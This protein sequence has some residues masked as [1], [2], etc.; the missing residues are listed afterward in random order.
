MMK[1]RV[2]S[3]I[4]LPYESVME[5]SEMARMVVVKNPEGFA[6]PLEVTGFESSDGY[7]YSPEKVARNVI[8][9]LVS[10]GAIEDVDWKYRYDAITLAEDTRNSTAELELYV[11]IDVTEELRR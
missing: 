7:W 6:D 5:I 2:Y 3:T 11:T 1:K 9:I 10:E 8:S 4:R